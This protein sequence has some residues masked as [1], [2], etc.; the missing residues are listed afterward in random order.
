MKRN[1]FAEPE[2][3][4]AEQ[5]RKIVGVGCQGMGGGGKGKGMKRGIKVCYVYQLHTQG[6]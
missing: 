5:S 3:S 6:I 4:F 2:E 1:F